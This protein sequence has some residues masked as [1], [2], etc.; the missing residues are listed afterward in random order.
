MQGV[1]S[2]AFNPEGLRA[3]AKGR[4]VAPSLNRPG[5]GGGLPRPCR[6]GAHRLP[7]FHGLRPPKRGLHLWLQPATPLGLERMQPANQLMLKAL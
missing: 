7:R 5:R 1:A 3:I 6:G 2:S 4:D